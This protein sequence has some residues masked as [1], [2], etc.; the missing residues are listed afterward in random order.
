[1][2]NLSQDDQICDTRLAVW[3][4]GPSPCVP[5]GDS[6]QTVHVVD[7]PPEARIS[8]ISFYLYHSVG[9]MF[10]STLLLQCTLYH[11]TLL[12]YDLYTWYN[13]KC[14]YRF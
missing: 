1:M 9:I 2:V 7:L 6:Q 8:A 4:A 12:T 5:G 14:F 10:I 13:F 11:K 3:G